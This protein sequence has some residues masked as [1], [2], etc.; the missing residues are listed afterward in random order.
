SGNQVIIMTAHGIQAV[1]GRCSMPGMNNLMIKV[2][3][4]AID[5]GVFTVALCYDNDV[6]TQQRHSRSRSTIYIPR[7]HLLFLLSVTHISCFFMLI[8]FS[9]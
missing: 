2:R 9:K 6:D 1:N 5:K 8:D 3:H 4:G 7:R